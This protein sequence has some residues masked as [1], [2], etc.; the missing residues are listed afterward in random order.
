MS[1]LSIA[2]LVFATLFASVAL[3]M[4]LVDHPARLGLGGLAPAK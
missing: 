4:G 3:Y 1:R 2:A